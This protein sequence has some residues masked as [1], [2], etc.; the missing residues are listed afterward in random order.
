[1][2]LAA[3]TEPPKPSRAT[4]LPAGLLGAIFGLSLQL[5]Q[6][7]LSPLSLYLAGC[8]LAILLGALSLSSS[9]RWPRLWL[10]SLCVAL[11]A[12]LLMASTTGW[13]A[14]H[15]QSQA[16]DPALEG[17]DLRLTGRI[18]AMPQPGENSLRFR[19]AVE[20]AEQITA[21]GPVAVQ[22]PPRIELNW[23][24]PQRNEDGALPPT[25]TPL[26][27]LQAGDRWRL[28]ARLRA[29][30][31]T[32]NPHGFDAELWLWEQGVQATGYVRANT[33][34]RKPDLPPERL[35]PSG[36]HRME[37]A[38]QQ[39]RDAIVQR[40]KLATSA[41]TLTDNTAYRRALGV[42]AALVTGDQ[43]AISRSDWDVFRATGVAHL[44]SI[45]GLHITAF[46][47]LAALLLQA[48]WRRSAWMCLRYPAQHAGLLGGVLLAAAYAVFSGWGVPAQR[49]VLMLATVSLLRLTARRWPW[50]LL[51]LLTAVVVLVVD[52]WALLQ[53]G[54]WLSFVAVG[55]LFAGLGET[56]TNQTPTLRQRALGLLREQGTIT[57]ALAPLT[58]LLFGQFSLVSLGANLLAIP[59]VT[60]V[61]TPLAMA[62][63]FISPLWDG[64]A[65]AVQGLAMV[66]EPLAALPWATLSRAQAPLWASLAAVLGG[67]LL[68]WRLPWA[69][70]IAGVP[71]L[72][73][74]LLW[75][76]A[77]PAPGQFELL[78]V[79][80]GQGHAVLVR[81]ATHALLYDTG[82]R[83]TTDSDA[84]ERL[85][86]PL[87][88]AQGVQLD[89]LMLS[90]RDSDHTG[91]AASVLGAQPQADLISSLEP[92]HELHALRPAKQSQRCEIGQSWTWDG[93]EMTVLHP[94]SSDYGHTRRS[95]AISCVL[96]ISNGQQT[97]LLVGDIEKAQ[98]QR[99]VQEQAG[100]LRAD[101]LLVPHHGS[102]T[103]STPEFLDAVAPRF[104][105]VQAGYRNR[106]GHPAEPV[107]AR[108]AE[109]NIVVKN[110]AACG[111]SS[112]QSVKPD[113]ISC[114][115]ELRPRYWQHRVPQRTSDNNPDA[116]P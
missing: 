26:P 106:Y 111:A 1:M 108:Y 29:P 98:E 60:L 59:W 104:A 52:P 91:G 61:V 11:A 21:D 33:S 65:W 25:A 8:G 38:R 3:Q 32:R 14:V 63:M 71:L 23:Y 24:G 54:F 4:L 22:V 37:W 40:A 67:V 46:A 47:W 35:G 83:Y 2:P 49:T 82:P 72:L 100:S 80:I 107:L 99:L 74:V 41:D 39:V 113:A 109:R 97:A 95:N 93:V 13:R 42:V 110:T 58:L 76:P 70:R 115:R 12:G 73:P 28:Q 78:A 48:L 9:M 51:W 89:R 53:A 64:A 6:A 27:Q 15:Y 69:M 19:F 81:T 77:R 45:S 79:D 94:W 85:L 10:R 16:L 50:P 34:A 84:G 92:A 18:A 112:W 68:V 116:E 56:A 105:V 57:L 7:E 55:V 88:R 31:G 30:H 86:I 114:E 44:M 87:L 36:Q 90:H 101:W 20:Q 5:Q 17:V 96:R 75:Q 62:G 103:S 43:Q 102:K 66:L